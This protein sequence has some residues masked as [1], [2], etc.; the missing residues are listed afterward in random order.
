LIQEFDWYREYLGS[1]GVDRTANTTP[2]NKSGGLSTIT[3]KALGSI[4]KSG[5][6]EILDVISPGMRTRKKGLNFLSGPASDF[7]CGTL[8]LAAGAN[9]HLFS[10]GR[11]T[12]YSI[13]GFP[14]IKIG[15]N[16]KLKQ[17]WFDLIDFDA[18][19]VAFGQSIN[20]CALLLMQ[21]IQKVASG[22]K[23]AAEKLEISNDLVLFNP[24]AI[25]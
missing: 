19:K 2:G 20:E 1:H 11:G 9:I 22:Q 15:T 16:T 24:A 12:P 21:E 3:E 18:G 6:S 5:N 13:D 8:E 23:T 17:K 25:T 14:V 4:A 7:I 10:T